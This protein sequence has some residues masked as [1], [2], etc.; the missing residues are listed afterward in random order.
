[1]TVL[2]WK[3][4]MIR[5]AGEVGGWRGTFFA[6]TKRGRKAV[7]GENKRGEGDDTELKG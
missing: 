4:R 7:L 5:K 2:L 1:V 3:K 6:S